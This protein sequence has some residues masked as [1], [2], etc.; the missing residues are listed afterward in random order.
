MPFRSIH[1][2]INDDVKLNRRAIRLDTQRLDEFTMHLIKTDSAMLD[3]YIAHQ[4]FDRQTVSDARW[5][6]ELHDISVRARAYLLHIIRENGYAR[7][8]E[9][10]RRCNPTLSGE[11]IDYWFYRNLLILAKT[12]NKNAML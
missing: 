11:I 4:G 6:M 3:D 12:A 7:F 5:S 9:D 8:V 2:K 1:D 10:Y